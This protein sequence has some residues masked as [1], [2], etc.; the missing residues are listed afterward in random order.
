[1]DIV[2]PVTES[3]SKVFEKDDLFRVSVWIII[4]GR[5]SAALN[6]MIVETELF[7]ERFLSIWIG[8]QIAPKPDCRKANCLFVF[9]P[10]R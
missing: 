4:F 1:M 5:G 3:F 8:S 9:D 2:W 10:V 6:F 7:I